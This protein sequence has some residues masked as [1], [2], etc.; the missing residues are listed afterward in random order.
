M[1]RPGLRSCAPRD[2]YS[3]DR[4]DDLKVEAIRLQPLTGMGKRECARGFGKP[5]ETV[6]D[7]LDPGQPKKHPPEDFVTWV[8][9][10]ASAN[11][12]V[13]RAS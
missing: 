5:W 4:A 13:R 1:T 3:T 9:H 11:A 6:R 10:R 12:L 2:P 7:W 8:R